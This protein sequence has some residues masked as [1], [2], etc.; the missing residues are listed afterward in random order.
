M[1]IMTPPVG[2]PDPL[3]PFSR[4]ITGRRHFAMAAT[5]TNA[6]S[7]ASADGA[8][9][10]VVAEGARSGGSAALATR[11]HEFGLTEERVNMAIQTARA[12]ADEAKR[13]LEALELEAKIRFGDAQKQVEASIR[14]KPMQAAGI[15]FAAGVLATL[16][17]RRR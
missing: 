9:D 14:E 12:S 10:A 16:F 15:A 6:Q 3:A 11:A 13:A 2:G 5:Q 1:R 4:T 7:D 17:L 8:N